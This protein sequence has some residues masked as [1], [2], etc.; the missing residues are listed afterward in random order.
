MSMN[1]LSVDGEFRYIIQ[2]FNEW[3]ELQRDDFVYVLV[4]YLTRDIPGSPGEGGNSTYINGIV[5]S[6][7]TSGVQDKPMSLFQCRVTI[8]KDWILI[9][10]CSLPVISPFSDRLN[11]FVN[12]IQSGRPTLNANCKR[13]S[14][15]SIQKWGKKSSMN[16]RGHI[17][18]TM[19]THL[20]I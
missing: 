16:W 10:I 19:V 4:E 17:L 12:G 1:N 3:S 15:K 14:T 8:W 7:A 18:C 13:K 6:L 9:F 11:C 2:W 20:F 5:N